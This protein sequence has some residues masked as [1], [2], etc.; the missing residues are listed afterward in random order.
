MRSVPS[1]P[2]IARLTRSFASSTSRRICLASS[3]NTVPM[4]DRRILRPRRSNKVAPSS[5][6]NALM[7]WE[8]ADWTTL[9]VSAA[10]L[11]FC[12]SAAAR[13]YLRVLMS[14]ALLP[15]EKIIGEVT[16]LSMDQIRGVQRNSLSRAA[17][18]AAVRFARPTIGGNW[19][20]RSCGDG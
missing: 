10:R 8:S 4:N 20:D 2:S 12:V 1:S 11:R 3:R 19:R 9:R 5:S 16:N 18:A 13:K 7:R 14:I 6:S 17:S 15:Y